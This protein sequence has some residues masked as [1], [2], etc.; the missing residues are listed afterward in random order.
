MFK[1]VESRGVPLEIIVDYLDSQNM[2]VDWMDFYERSQKCNWNIK[3]TLNKIEVSLI[4]THG[5][6]YTEEVMKRL[7][8]CIGKKYENERSVP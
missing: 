1:L 3:T 2:I 6:E 4:D 5:K 7:K 8:Y